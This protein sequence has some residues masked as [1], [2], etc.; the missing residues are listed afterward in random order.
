MN[1][2]NSF[3]VLGPIMIGPSSSHTAGAARLGNIA[4]DIAKPDF[5]KVEFYL[6]GSFAKTYRGHGTDKALIGGILGFE[7]DDKRII[8]STDYAK[9]ANI[10]IE[11][12]ETDLGYF[13][14]NTVK[15]VFKYDDGEDFYV[16]GSSIGGG[17]VIIYDINGDQMEF[18]GDFPTLLLKYNDNKGVIMTISA[19]LSSRDHNIGKMNVIRDKDIATMT[20]E[21]DGSLTDD[22]VERL[23]EI[24]DVFYVQYID[25]T[26]S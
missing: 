14:P 2:Y 19:V 9:E 12:I 20:L 17:N 1:D 10:D 21:L 4:R 6:H 22:C 11:F 23:T 7:P 24:E 3:E 15:M 13:H 8:N 18:T 26:R 5:N 25:T 16:L